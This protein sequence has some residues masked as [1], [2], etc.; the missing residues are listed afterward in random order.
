MCGFV[1]MLKFRSNQVL[2][3]CF[4]YILNCW[5]KSNINKYLLSGDAYIDINNSVFFRPGWNWCL[6]QIIPTRPKQ[7]V[8]IF[9]LLH[10]TVLHWRTTL[11]T[12]SGT[13]KSFTSCL[14]AKTILH[15]DVCQGEREEGMGF[16]YTKT[17]YNH[18]LSQHRYWQMSGTEFRVS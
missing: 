11:C 13:R 7:E 3:P 6:G 15:F 5:L 9:S 17:D 8:A 1:F 2:P 16:P 12:T 4:F 14:W 18:L 10:T